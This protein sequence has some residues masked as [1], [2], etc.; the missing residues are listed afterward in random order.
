MLEL[1][2]ILNILSIILSIISCILFWKG[3]FS[4]KRRKLILYSF[5]PAGINMILRLILTLI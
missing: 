5:I 3:V 2:I 1:N 4:K